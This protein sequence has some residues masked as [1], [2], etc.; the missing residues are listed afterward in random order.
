MAPRRHFGRQRRLAVHGIP[1][2]GHRGGPGGRQDHDPH[3]SRRLGGGGLQHG[4]RRI[5]V[6]LLS[7]RHRNGSAGERP[8]KGDEQSGRHESGAAEP[9]AGRRRVGGGVLRRGGGAAAGRRLYKELQSEAGGGGGRRQ[10]GAGGVRGGG[11][12]HRKGPAG[13]VFVEGAGGG[14]GGHGNH[15]RADQADRLD[16][17]LS[18]LLLG[19]LCEICF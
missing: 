10:R 4:H 17:A 8:E 6:R 2:D 1:D 5:R 11:G 19:F 3:R 16:W 15:F 14:M 18:L 7:V 12:R 13:E 9:A